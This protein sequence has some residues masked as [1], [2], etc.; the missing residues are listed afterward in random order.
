M[1]HPEKWADL[2][3]RVS[4]ALILVVVGGLA[5]WIGAPLLWPLVAVLGGLMLWEVAQMQL[6]DPPA[7]GGQ[8]PVAQTDG[9]RALGARMVGLLSAT[10][11]ALVLWRHDA[12]LMPALL[13]PGIALL[14]MPGRDRLLHAIFA[15]V[16]MLAVYAFAAFREGYGLY[17]TLWLVL[18]VVASDVMGFFGGRALGGPKFWPR[19]SPKKTWSGTIAGWIGA[20]IVGILFALWFDAPVLPVLV[21]SVLT[22]FAA[23][24]GDIAESFLKRRAGVKDSSGL[25]PGHGGVLDRFDAMIGASAFLVFWAVARLPVPDFGN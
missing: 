15:I 12:W 10:V 21:V 16:V 3:V 24:M 4:S 9:T 11:I 19:V 14:V 6:T 23:Q 20:G 17:F 18:V 8:L 7:A 1:I 25:I 5:I 2:H 13:L 22:A